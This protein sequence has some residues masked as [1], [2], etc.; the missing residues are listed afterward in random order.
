MRS[1]TSV[2]TIPTATSVSPDPVHLRLARRR[3][4]ACR[5]AGRPPRPVRRWPRSPTRQ[6][7]AAGGRVSPHR[8]GAPLV[9]GPFGGGL[10]PPS[11]PRPRRRPP[12][13]AST[14]PPRRRSSRARPCV[15]S[16]GRTA[17]TIRRNAGPAGGGGTLD[18]PGPPRPPDGPPGGRHREISPLRPARRAPLTG[19]DAPRRA[20]HRGLLSR[21]APRRR[22]SVRRDTQLARVGSGQHRPRWSRPR[23]TASPGCGGRCARRRS[24]W[25][26]VEDL[27][28]SGR[29]IGRSGVG[30]P[31]PP[32]PP[33][34]GGASMA[35]EPAGAFRGD[36]RT[37]QGAPA[38]PSESPV[39]WLRT[40]R[41]G[42][43]GGPPNDAV[44]VPRWRSTPG[45][46]PQRP[47]PCLRSTPP[48]PWSRRASP[49]ASASPRICASGTCSALVSTAECPWTSTR[50]PE[51]RGTS[52]RPAPP[53]SR[54][55]DPG[56][57]ATTPPGACAASSPRTAPT[58]TPR[59]APTSSPAASTR[60]A[61]A[62]SCSAGPACPARAGA[63]GTRSGRSRIGAGTG[64]GRSGS[65]ACGSALWALPAEPRRRG[66]RGH[67][68]D[69][70]TPSAQPPA[71]LGPGP[72]RRPARWARRALPRARAP[73]P[74]PWPRP[75][76]WGP[77][78]IVAVIRPLVSPH[79]SPGP[80]R[81]GRRSPSG[82]VR[83][84]RAP[85]IRGSARPPPRRCSGP[86]GR[87]SPPRSGAS[88]TCRS[89]A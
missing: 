23:G 25:A 63:R 2:A 57:G 7:Q 5:D 78:G 50:A 48:R 21:P 29:S 30:P 45:R 67:A 11:P 13:C 59:G 70:P 20:R 87:S 8:E 51:R 43:L 60:R 75:A 37:R 74:A 49:C 53:S 3:G 39:S 36:A 22:R 52:S 81:P 66:L 15:S 47:G 26:S 86:R 80:R 84:P 24:R 28:G 32:A 27:G 73:G 17:R 6:V 10:R 41:L 1:A 35:H 46:R 61:A 14:C 34:R 76:A 33:E 71:R 68:L 18:P 19:E 12:C 58:R 54:T 72:H 77:S 85:P 62:R 64:E 4:G 88:R 44:T 16:R 42:G 56:P 79:P 69:A 40:H 83:R 89:P 55:L 9:R 65:I 31:T 38:A 82:R